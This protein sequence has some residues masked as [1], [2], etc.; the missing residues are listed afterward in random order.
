[1]CKQL[2]VA[3]LVGDHMLLRDFMPYSMILKLISGMSSRK[4]GVVQRF[5]GAGLA[6]ALTTG[7]AIGVLSPAG[8]EDF[9]CTLCVQTG[10]GA[11]PAF[12]TMGTGGTFPGGKSAAGA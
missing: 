9:S 1:V 10:S 8:E 6:Q 12:C 4:F 3:L 2:F 11:H 5:G 7:W